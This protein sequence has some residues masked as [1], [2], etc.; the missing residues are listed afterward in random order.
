MSA[1]KAKQVRESKFYDE[2]PCCRIRERIDSLGWTLGR[3]A[4]EMRSGGIANVTAEA[5]RQ[6]S[7]GYARPDMTKLKEISRVLNCS[8][9]YL[10]GVDDL[11]DMT[12]SQIH[13]LIGLSNNSIEQLQQYNTQRLNYKGD[14][15]EKMIDTL[16]ALLE[17]DEGRKILSHISMY[18]NVN[19]NTTLHFG[20]KPG[21]DNY[22]QWPRLDYQA[23][24]QKLMEAQ[25]ILDIQNQLVDLKK[26]HGSGHAYSISISPEEEV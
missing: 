18:L 10:F 22:R 13:N 24:A 9:N 23:P 3:A 5:V 19:V 16:N 1:E 15:P 11:P 14:D 2:Y 6:W 7:G 25:C 17:S 26:K 21:A 20:E 12:Q 4:E 8:I